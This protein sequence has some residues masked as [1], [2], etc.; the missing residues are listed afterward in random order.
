[1]T[2][3]LLIDLDGTLWDHEDISLL[4]PPFK[5]INRYIF[6]DINGNRVRLNLTMVKFIKW[7]RKNGAI[8]STLSWNL[9]EPAYQAIKTFNLDKLF[10]YIVIEPT[11]RKDQMIKQ[12]IKKIE[13]NIGKHIKP[14]NIVYIDDR[15][16]HINDIYKNIGKIYF[17]HY[18]QLKYNLNELVREVYNYL[19]KSKII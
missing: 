12:L 16:I 5:K 19:R 15:D 4:N 1:M 10:D 14:K 9:Y 13:N 18:N 3:V 17:I 6:Q 8:T 11:P 2:W 7:A